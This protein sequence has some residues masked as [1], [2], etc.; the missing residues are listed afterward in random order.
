MKHYT[1]DE[2]DRY[3]NGDMNMLIRISCASHLKQCDGCRNLLEALGKDDEF[4]EAV[5]KSVIRFKEVSEG[6]P[7]DKCKSTT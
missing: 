5:R 3:R 7:R 6:L 4:L 1:I 2:L